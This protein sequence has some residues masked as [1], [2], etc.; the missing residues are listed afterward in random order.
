MSSF[1]ER[2]GLKKARDVI[3]LNGIDDRLRVAIY[4]FLHDRFNSSWYIRGNV[5]GPGFVAARMVWTDHWYQ[6]ADEFRQYPAEFTGLLRD[7]IKKRP[8]NEV[9]D[10]LEFVVSTLL[11]SLTD[12]DVNAILERERSGYR[13]RGGTLVPVS[14]KS[15]LDAIDEALGAPEPFRGA[16]NHIVDALEKLA[17]RPNPD[18]R[19]AITEAVSAVESA[20]R[21]VTG[22][23]KAT[24]G[25][26]LKALEKAGHVHPALK[27]AWMKLYGYTSDEHGLRHAMTERSGPTRLDSSGG[28]YKCNPGELRVIHGPARVAHATHTSARGGG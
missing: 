20:A 2:M 22:K 11:L 14:D 1:S 18:V 15:E 17:Q 23:P 8:W 6:P 3:Q 21:V 25:D 7:Y 19:N 16:R 13:M 27:D 24:L 26:A 12:R 4:N 28:V 5:G 9:Y 10:L